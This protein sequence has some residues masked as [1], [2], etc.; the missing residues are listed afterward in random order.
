MIKKIRLY[1]LHISVNQP[2]QLEILV[3]VTKG[4][5]ELLGNFEETHEEEE[6]EDGEDG[7][8][9]V[10]VDGHPVGRVLVLPVP[11]G[12]HK[13][14]VVVVQL[15]ASDQTEDEEHI[16]GQGHHLLEKVIREQAHKCSKLP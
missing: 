2:V 15:L 7:E 16:G 10:E 4:V 11:Y 14:L 13:T 1:H 6:L 5:D 8:V 12:T 3:V 9:E